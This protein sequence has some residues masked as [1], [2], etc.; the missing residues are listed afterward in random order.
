MPLGGTDSARK[1]RWKEGRD[2]KNAEKEQEVD[3]HAK[4]VGGRC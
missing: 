2:D 4:R 3:E 1:G